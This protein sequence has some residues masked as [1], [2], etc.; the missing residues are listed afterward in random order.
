MREKIII[1][2]LLALLIGL[3]FYTNKGNEEIA[4]LELNKEIAEK[5]IA[6]LNGDI[7]AKNV[8]IDSLLKEK[9]KSDT[10]IAGLNEDI[11]DIRSA[12]GKRI[13]SLSHLTATQQVE[14]FNLYTETHVA[15]TNKV[16]TEGVRI[17]KANE[18]F[19]KGEATEKELVVTKNIVEEQWKSILSLEGVIAKQADVITLKQKQLDLR[20]EQMNDFAAIIKE[21]DK[22]IRK[23]KRKRLW[24]TIGSGA[25]ILLLL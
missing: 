25:V 3:C 24:T 13:D 17:A 9:I 7:S 8:R 19:V 14:L 15:D 2:V 18:L 6:A 1:G 16:V 21:K 23:E 22:Q 20:L 5:K 10:I 4:R 11:D 12:Y